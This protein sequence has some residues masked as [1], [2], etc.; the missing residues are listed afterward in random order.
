MVILNRAVNMGDASMK[1]IDAGKA[2][3]VVRGF[4]GTV[5]GTVGRRAH[6]HRCGGKRKG[7]N[8][9]DS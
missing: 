1:H 4:D 3:G 7:I 6:V 8:V 9:G 5:L 2:D